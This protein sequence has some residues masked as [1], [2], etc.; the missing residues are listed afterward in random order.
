MMRHVVG[1]TLIE[2]LVTISIAAILSAV[3]VPTYQHSRDKS[4][5]D[6]AAAKL[7][8]ALSLARQAAITRGE[9]TIVCP[10]T[11]G[12]SCEPGR[13]YS[14]G[15]IAFVDINGSGEFEKAEESSELIERVYGVAGGT[16]ISNRNKVV[17]NSFGL[18]TGTNQSIVYTHA[19]G[20]DKLQRKV[21]IN[22]QGR[23][24]IAYA[25]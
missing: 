18:L 5:A 4:N 7:Q 6:Q 16:M 17:Y 19:S 20:E 22:R 1:Y 14:K 15:A 8:Q 23:I 9:T 2:L 21:V 25:D 3:A 24:R 13:D 12:L 11:D 10:S